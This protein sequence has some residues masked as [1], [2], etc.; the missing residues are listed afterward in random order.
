MSSER[1]WRRTGIAIMG[2][3][4][5]LLLCASASASGDKILQAECPSRSGETVLAHTKKSGITLSLPGFCKIA[6]HRFPE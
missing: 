2:I 4:F 5:L 1:S 6:K 3:L